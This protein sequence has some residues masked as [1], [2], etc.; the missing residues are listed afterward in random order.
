MVW[1][2]WRPEAL[3]ELEGVEHLALR[4]LSEGEQEPENQVWSSKPEGLE[5]EPKV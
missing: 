5:P 2:Y 1:S 3:G 4:R